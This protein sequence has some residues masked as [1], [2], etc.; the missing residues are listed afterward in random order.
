MLNLSI[1]L[2]FL[3]CLFPDFFYIC[4]R[5]RGNIHG[6]SKIPYIVVIIDSQHNYVGCFRFSP[7]SPFRNPVFATGYGTM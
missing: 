1:C 6:R 2:S 5:F 3:F 7:P 4:R